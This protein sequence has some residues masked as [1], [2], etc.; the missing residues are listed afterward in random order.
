MI[1]FS[2]ICLALTTGFVFTQNVF[3]PEGEEFPDNIPDGDNFIALHYDLFERYLNSGYSVAELYIGLYKYLIRTQIVSW[4]FT[5]EMRRIK[6]DL[7]KI[8][9]Q[10][11]EEDKEVATFVSQTNDATER[12]LK[13]KRNADKW[14]V[15]YD[16]AIK[17]IEKRK[18]L[19]SVYPLGKTEIKLINIRKD[20]NEAKY[21]LKQVVNHL[22]QFYT[23][24][25]DCDPNV[26]YK[27]ED[28][29]PY[30]AEVD[31]DFEY[32]FL[33]IT[34]KALKKILGLIKEPESRVISGLISAINIVPFN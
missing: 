22:E 23:K 6:K 8:G 9:I 3:M 10:L 2:L 27:I 4:K 14:S 24:I 20:L 7:A 12:V 16:T 29:D 33:E 26:V 21:N 17:W 30:F 28:F 34:D 13:F 1:K 15:V 18:A 31:K 32:N 25:K 5:L 11:I 19:F